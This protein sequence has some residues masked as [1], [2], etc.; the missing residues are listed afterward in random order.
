MNPGTQKLRGIEIDLQRTKAR[1]QKLLETL[2]DLDDILTI[3]ISKARN[4]GK[5]MTPWEVAAKELGLRP[6]P[7][8]RRRKN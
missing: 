5:P 8:K 6:P 3:E 4:A 7:K 1:L 2:E